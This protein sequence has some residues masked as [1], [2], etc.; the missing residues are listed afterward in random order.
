M[1]V[2]YNQFPKVL[3]AASLVVQEPALVAS[4]SIPRRAKLLPFVGTTKTRCNGG[5]LLRR[6]LQLTTS[7]TILSTIL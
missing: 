5:H 1:F 2:R 3:L 4:P 7:S 6:Y